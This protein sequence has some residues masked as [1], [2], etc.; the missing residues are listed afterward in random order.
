MGPSPPLSQTG[1]ILAPL[2]PH[3][4]DQSNS[5]FHPW[6]HK[7]QDLPSVQAGLELPVENKASLTEN[8]ASIAIC[9]KS[10]MD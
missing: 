9:E 7:Y 2:L 3:W 8:Q 1:G 6:V 4:A 5:P 10:G